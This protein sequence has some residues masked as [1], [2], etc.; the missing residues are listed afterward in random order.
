MNS[1]AHACQTCFSKPLGL[2][3]RKPLKVTGCLVSCCRAKCALVAALISLRLIRL[4]G[5]LG[6]R[7]RLGLQ[8]RFQRGL[9][10]DQRFA[11]RRRELSRFSGGGPHGQVRLR[12][13]CGQ[14]QCLGLQ[15]RFQRGPDAG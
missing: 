12:D 14:R 3:P 7:Q 15:H 2:L 11:L 8:H 1:A 10:A 13:K 6:Q 5:K 9:N 4:R